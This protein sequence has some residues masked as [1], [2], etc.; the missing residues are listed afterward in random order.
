MLF[1]SD[2]LVQSLSLARRMEIVKMTQEDALLSR[3]ERR[4]LLGYEPDDQP[5][6]VSLHYID[7]SHAT[8]YQLDNIKKQN[9]NPVAT[10]DTDADDDQPPAD[11][12][13]AAD[14]K[15]PEED[16]NAKTTD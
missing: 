8:D 4:E 1:R 9:N 3:P 2:R 12:A 13:D 16:N 10:A 14:D 7:V 11:D 5:T 6:R 15:K